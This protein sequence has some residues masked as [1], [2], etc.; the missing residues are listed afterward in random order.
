ML[1]LLAHLLTAP[2][3][4]EPEQGGRLLRW[5]FF[6]GLLLLAGRLQVG[7]YVKDGRLYLGGWGQMITS[8]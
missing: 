3:N 7:C 8:L 1:R 4:H 2:K 6:Q 5:E